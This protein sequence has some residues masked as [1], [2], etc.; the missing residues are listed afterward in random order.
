MSVATVANW[1]SNFLISVS[2]LTLVGLISRPGTF[3]V[4]GVL[5]VAAVVFFAARVP[6]TKEKSLE[7]IQAELEPAGSS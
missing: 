1:A 5:G 7:E 3:V 2:F 6:E 4:Y